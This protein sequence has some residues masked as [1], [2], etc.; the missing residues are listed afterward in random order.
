MK[1]IRFAQEK[2]DSQKEG[3]IGIFTNNGFLENI[4]FSGMRSSLMRSFDQ[5]LALDLHG[6]GRKQ[7]ESDNG[8]KDENV[9][10]ILTGI[11]VV[12][13]IKK[14]GLEKGIFRRDVFGSCEDKYQFLAEHSCVDVEQEEFKINP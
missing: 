9:F 8:E 7:E 10:G 12:F 4:T 14:T 2:I 3:I 5:I 11:C 13:F 1:F 6:N